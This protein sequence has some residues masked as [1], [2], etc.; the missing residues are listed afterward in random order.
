MTRDPQS[1]RLGILMLDTHFPRPPGDIGHPDTFPFPVTFRRVPGADAPRAVGDRGAGLLPAFIAEGRALVAEG[2]DAVATSCGFL[3]LFQAPLAEAL[4]V[5]VA[6]SPLMQVASVQ[7]L[8]PPGRRAGVLTIS[9]ADL[10]PDHLAAAG[11]DP[12]TPV[13]GTPRGSAFVRAILGDLPDLDPDAAR[14]DLVAAARA[15]HA[16]H[17]DLGALVLECTNMGPWSADIRAATSL[18]VFDTA[19]FL[20]WVHAGLAPRRFDPRDRPTAAARSL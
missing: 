11:A 5:P 14:A 8:L 4:G 9:P 18:P 20:A 10:T 2:I 16:A 13:G 17:P 7:R 3:S 19:S 12:A 15:F 1:P 6:A